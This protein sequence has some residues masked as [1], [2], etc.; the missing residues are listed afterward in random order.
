[1]A[2]DL[3]APALATDA[4]PS[5]H[6]AR[7]LAAILALPAMWLDRA[8][9]AIA[10]DLLAILA[11]ML[12]LRSA[13]ARFDGLGGAARL[14]CWLP[15]GPRPPAEFGPALDAGDA[16]SGAV[17]VARIAPAIPGEGGLVLASSERSDF[18][19]PAELHLLRAASGQATVSIAAARRL[20]AERSARLAAQTALRIRNAFLVD[21]ARD[22]AAPRDLLAER[23]AQAQRL[24]AEPEPPPAAAF[25]AAPHALATPAGLTR[26]EVEVL[27]L[28]AQGLSNKEIAAVLSLSDRTVERHITGVYRKIG[29]ERR[30]EATAF[31]LRHG[32]AGPES[33]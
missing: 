27:G 11:S 2:S 17:R 14:E 23:A 16:R 5:T 7:D 28:L 21:L 32:L 26:R 22:L 4:G 15:E 8:P 29:V 18:P 20:A 31:A 24:A 19:T 25:A 3:A 10:S 13:Y 6:L 9:A 1:M 30:S 12:R 33:L